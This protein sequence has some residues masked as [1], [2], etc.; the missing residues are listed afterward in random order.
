MALKVLSNNNITCDT[1][2]SGI[3]FLGERGLTPDGEL[4]CSVK[5]GWGGDLSRRISQYKT[6]S[7]QLFH[8]QHHVLTKQLPIPSGYDMETFAHSMLAVLAIGLPSYSR[9]WYYVSEPVYFEL[10]K[11]PWQIFD[12][13]KMGELIKLAEKTKKNNRYYI[14]KTEYDKIYKHDKMM[15]EQVINRETVIKQQAE[16][17]E[18]LNKTRQSY[19]E[20]IQTYAKED[21][22][23]QYHYE[24]SVRFH[25]A[26]W[27][28]K[29]LMALNII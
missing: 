21:K 27:W 29:I 5:I 26:P 17:I 4:L 6:H 24:Y 28:K 2:D 8:Q 15:T 22:L 10:C 19:F 12:A 7:C 23:K 3:Y 9:E 11:D 16:E 18:A 1:H 13:D 20:L 25:L 14:N